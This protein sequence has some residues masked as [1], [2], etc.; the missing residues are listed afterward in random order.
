MADWDYAAQD[1]DEVHIVGAE[2]EDEGTISQ[3]DCW[4]VIQ[5]YFD[6]NV[7]PPPLQR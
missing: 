5:S 1:D 3:G 6:E 2:E 7:P 4:S